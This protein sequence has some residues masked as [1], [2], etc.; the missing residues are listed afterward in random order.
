MRASS[1]QRR[2]AIPSARPRKGGGNSLRPRAGEG[3]GPARQPAWRQAATRFLAS[4]ADAVAWPHW[5]SRRRYAS[6][7]PP[8]PARNAG[9]LS[10]GG[11]GEDS[12]VAVKEAW[13]SARTLHLSLRERSTPKAAGEGGM[14]R[15]CAKRRRPSPG[16]GRLSHGHILRRLPASACP[17]AIE[18]KFSTRRVASS[19]RT[20]GKKC[21]QETARGKRG[22][23]SY[24][25]SCV[26]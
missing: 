1:H 11:R 13:S 9:G 2:A 5:G 10:Q 7:K 26:R 12:Q 20:A 16:P 8:S 14:R 15:R 3:L 17:W 25:L 21:G 4:T 19:S 22:A 24:D 18:R 23:D 6:L